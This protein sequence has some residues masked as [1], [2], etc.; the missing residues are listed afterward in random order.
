MTETLLSPP[1]ASIVESDSDK[2]A[3]E[4]LPVVCGVKESCQ[5]IAAD[6]VAH[7]DSP[8]PLVCTV[9]NKCMQTPPTYAKYVTEAAEGSGPTSEAPDT[10]LNIM[11]CTCS[12]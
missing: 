5:G 6:C 3:L 8:N 7:L 10:Q 2:K 9:N 12:S 11:C 4:R 1:V